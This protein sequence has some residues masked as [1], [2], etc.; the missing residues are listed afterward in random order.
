M[1]LGL[2]TMLAALAASACASGGPT[3]TANRMTV[4]VK[5]E[6]TSAITAYALWNGTRVRLGDVAA[7]NTR[8]FTTTRRDRVGLGIEVLSTPPPMTGAGPSSMAGGQAPGIGAL[9]TRS[10][11]ILL[12]PTE[13]IEFQLNSS[14]SLVFRRLPG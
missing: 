2:L 7:R 14:G 8:T 1:R 10:E 11:E 9:L 6:Y 5:N 4:V 12:S 3:D 13:G